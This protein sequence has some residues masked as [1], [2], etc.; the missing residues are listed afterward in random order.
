MRLSISKGIAPISANSK[1]LVVRLPPENRNAKNAKK[2]IILG[3]GRLRQTRPE[4]VLT[5]HRDCRASECW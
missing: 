2:G 4:S 3:V 5:D 1:N